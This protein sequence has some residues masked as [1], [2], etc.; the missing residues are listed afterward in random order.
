ME[1]AEQYLAKAGGVGA[2][3]RRAAR[4]AAE[5]ASVDVQEA[6]VWRSRPL[7][8]AA[9][10]VSCREEGVGTRS[11]TWW[12]GGVDASGERFWGNGGRSWRTRGRVG[13]ELELSGLVMLLL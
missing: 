11:P 4:G 3:T 10:D 12:G 6:R 2:R 1:P 5:R 13:L 9:G 7:R 8:D